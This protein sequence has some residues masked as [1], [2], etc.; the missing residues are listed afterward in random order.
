MFGWLR[1]A[2]ILSNP[3]G[4]NDLYDVDLASTLDLDIWKAS[5]LIENQENFSETFALHPYS[6]K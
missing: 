4:E 3:F 5:V 6:E 1:V 2:E